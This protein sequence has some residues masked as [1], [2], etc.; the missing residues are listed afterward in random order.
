MANVLT[1]PQS[2]AIASFTAAVQDLNAVQTQIADDDF[3]AIDFDD[4]QL[5]DALV[6]K[7]EIEASITDLDEKPRMP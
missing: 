3:V 4:Y 2:Q 7:I 1:V 6:R 5:A